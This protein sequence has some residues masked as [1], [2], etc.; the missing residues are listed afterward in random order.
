MQ[1]YN[2]PKG[3]EGG[4]PVFP[5]K[6]VLDILY[7]VDKLDFVCYRSVGRAIMKEIST[8]T[9]T[10]VKKFGHIPHKGVL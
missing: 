10:T 3:S 6:K 9:K 8:G 2:H 7:K 4:R 1:G 5:R